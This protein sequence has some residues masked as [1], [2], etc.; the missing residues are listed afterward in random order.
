MSKEANAPDLRA[1]A[2]AP[3]DR[4]PAP[5]VELRA[6]GYEKQAT[7]AALASLVAWGITVAPV[8]FA[9][10]APPL[11]RATALAA[12]L[13]GLAG[14]LLF[15]ARPRLGRALGLTSFLSL[16]TAT[17]LLAPAAI[18]PDR[19]DPT[20]ALLGSLAWG[21][22]ALSWRAPR[23]S[24]RPTT[25]EAGEPSLEARARLPR[26]IVPIAAMSIAA[27]LACLGAAWRARDVERALFAQ[28]TALVCAT[29]LLSAGTAI[30]LGRGE[31]AGRRRLPASA[32]RALFA[33][34]VV[35]LGAVLVAS[36][37]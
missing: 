29:A 8:A 25:P 11:A 21:L 24:P 7:R 10:S 20:H 28:A 2:S 18:R 23:P 22:Y 33:L 31:P 9:R 17:W 3:G 13:A 16:A 14:S 36:T 30:A 19:L 5:R 34:A 4:A 12:V 1:A 27:A 15:A 32:R 35:A 26:S 37:R 6:W